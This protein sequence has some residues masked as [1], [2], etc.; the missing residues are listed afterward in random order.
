MPGCLNKCLDKLSKAPCR[1]SVNNSTKFTPIISY[2][3]NKIY[4]PP[5]EYLAK[6][7]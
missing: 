3:T 1:Q 7:A 5:L 4:F 2:V 6:N